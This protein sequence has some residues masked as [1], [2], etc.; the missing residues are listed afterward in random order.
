MCIFADTK[1]VKRLV[2]VHLW[3]YDTKLVFV[4]L[5]KD[6]TKLLFVGDDTF[7]F[8][9]PLPTLIIGVHSRFYLLYL[10]FLFSLCWQDFV[11]VGSKWISTLVRKKTC[12]TAFQITLWSF[13]LLLF[14]L[15]FLLL[16]DCFSDYTL[17]FF[18]PLFRLYFLLLSDCFSDYTFEFGLNCWRTTVRKFALGV[19]II[20]NMIV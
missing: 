9:G 18:L 11:C 7:F 16:S 17:E 12:L 4:H 19:A 8:G 14:R 3:K 1:F 13:I 5:W 2:F 15:Y 10:N 20:K 6:D